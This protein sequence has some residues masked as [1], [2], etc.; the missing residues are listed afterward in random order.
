[1][2][3]FSWVYKQYTFSDRLALPLPSVQANSIGSK[4]MGFTQHNIYCATTKINPSF[5]PV[6]YVAN[7]NFG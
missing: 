6:W 3:T 5:K 7:D 1:M 4:N 2:S